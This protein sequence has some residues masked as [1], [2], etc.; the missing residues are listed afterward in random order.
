M[1]KSSTIQ[2]LRFPFSFFLMPVYLFALSSLL[3][4]EWSRAI[5]IFLIL[6]LLV[7]PSSNAYNSYMDRDQGSIGGIKA[8]MQP[9]RQLF[10][11]SLLLDGI[12]IASGFFISSLFVVGILFYILASRAYSYRGIRLKKYPF[13][14]YLTVFIFQG[15]VTFWLVY[16]GS[17]EVQTL[18]FP[19]SGMLASS[20]LIGGLYPL[21]Q[22]YQHEADRRDGVTSISSL[23][24]YRGTFIFTG[25]VFL[26]AF[27]VLAYHFF[28]GSQ[29]KQF[30]LV[31]IFMIPAIVYF[32]VW[33]TRVWKNKSAADF[34]STMKMNI[35]A[36]CCT[37]AAFITL[38]IWRFFE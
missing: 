27:V 20:L 6:H 33:A 35:L 31:Q 11:V 16:Y 21:T 18:Y 26:F 38:I 34:S 2:L 8:P 3:K 7:Y 25:I 29:V 1:L 36:S 22:I 37:N 9:T 24:G 32:F 28:S 4:P 10:T 19:V 23:L 12:A 30:L 17:Q 14:G 5:V 15:G 13:I